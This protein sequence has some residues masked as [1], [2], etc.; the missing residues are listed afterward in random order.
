MEFEIRGNPDYGHLHVD[1]A[2]GDTF[3]AESGAMS[4][5]DSGMKVR[6]RMLGGLVRSVFRKMLARESLL[7]GEYSHPSGGRVG[8]S[9]P[10]PGSVQHRR[11]D[12]EM[13]YLTRGTF[14]A[15][16]PGIELS[17]RFAGLRGFFSGEGAFLLRATGTGDLFFTSFGAIVERDISGGL[18][19]DTGHV[20]A[21]EETLEY[22]IGGMG[23]VKSTLFSGEGLT[24]RFSGTGKIWLQ[25]RTLP[26]LGNWVLPFLS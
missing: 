14:L 24:M 2:P 19:V 11:M 15:C 6:S 5:M 16:S 18:V 13:L 10:T 17:T 3:V 21:W 26:A 22:R 4:Y 23:G 12:G 7:V 9:P 8:L 20:V 1:L 25:T